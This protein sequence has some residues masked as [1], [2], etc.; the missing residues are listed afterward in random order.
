MR[1]DRFEAFFDAMMAIIMTIV[2]LEFAI[3][4]GTAWSDVQKLMFQIVVYAISFFYLGMMWMNIHTLWHNVEYI[5]RSVMWVNMI[6]LFFSSM[7]PFL[8][9]YLGKDHNFFALVPQLLYGIDVLLITITNLVS[10]E[11]LRKYNP[12]LNYGV[13]YVRSG[14]ILDITTKVVGIIIAIF[15]FPPA[16]TISVIVA[17]V[18]LSFNFT[19]LR[20]KKKAYM[21]RNN[22][23]TNE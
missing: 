2:V 11:L 16:I 15:W 7:I 21:Q 13:E 17:M 4:H 3:P 12:K 19:L 23:T 1:K 14:M 9:V 18:V 22:E 20:R 8:V 10:A 5:T 6:M